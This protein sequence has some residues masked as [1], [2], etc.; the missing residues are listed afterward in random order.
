MTT[1]KEIEKAIAELPP[2]KFFILRS[3]LE[4]FEAARWDKQL[5]ADVK[6]GKLDAVAAKVSENYKKG[7]CK[8]L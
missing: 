3:W 4:K 1:V 5:E 8:E 2:K 7:K 6:S